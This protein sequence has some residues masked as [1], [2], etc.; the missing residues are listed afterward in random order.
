LNERLNEVKSSLELGAD[1]I[2]VALPRGIDDAHSEVTAFREAAG[3]ARLKV[4]IETGE[5]DSLDE[6]ARIARAAIEG[7]TDFVKTSTGTERAPGA[8]IDA[9]QALA[10]VVGAHDAVGIKVSGGISTP[11]IAFAHMEVAER[12]LGNLDPRRFRIG[13]SRLLD[14]LVRELGS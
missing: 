11:D 5:L 4:I 2:D 9:T 6:V 10:S 1:E 14:G 13:A 3:T 7:G 8:S 12:A